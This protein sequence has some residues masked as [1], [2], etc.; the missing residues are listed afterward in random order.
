[1]KLSEIIRKYRQANGLSQREF[2]KRC[3]LSNSYISFIEN[4]C[5]P[6]TGRPLTP[7]IEQ[8]KKIADGMGFTVQK[9]F[10]SL[11]VDSPVILNKTPSS[12]SESEEAF[13]HYLKAV[14]ESRVENDLLLIYRSLSIHGKNKLI[15]R[16]KELQLLYGKKSESDSA[17][18]V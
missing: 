18:S 6:K 15:E 13:Q 4:E 11:D 10:E 1:M 8:Y 7:N 17:Q 5:N 12:T 3:G 16:A 14:C 2:A 9:L